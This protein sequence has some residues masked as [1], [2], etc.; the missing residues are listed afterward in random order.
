MPD[1]SAFQFT[2]EQ[3][4]EAV[5]WLADNCPELFGAWPSDNHDLPIKYLIDM[6]LKLKHYP[7]SFRP[8][9]FIIG[10]EY[11]KADRVKLGLEAPNISVHNPHPRVAEQY[12]HDENAL[13][14]LMSILNNAKL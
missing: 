5:D 4:K 12:T 1:K 9:Q 6:Y 3:E 7:Y 10:I 11:K 13:L 8:N 2:P 14:F